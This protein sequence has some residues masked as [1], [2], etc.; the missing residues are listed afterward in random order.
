MTAAAAAPA[1]RK[2]PS[3]YRDALRSVPTPYSPYADRWILSLIP[4]LSRQGIASGI[5]LY[6]YQQTKAG[7]W[8]R[9]SYGEHARLAKCSKPGITLALRFLCDK[10]SLL[11]RRQRE[12]TKDEREIDLRLADRAWDLLA[13]MEVPADEDPVRARVVPP[14]GLQEWTVP[15]SSGG[16][17]ERVG[18]INEAAGY[19]VTV[20]P[21]E[22]ISG[23]LTFHIHSI[24]PRESHDSGISRVVKA[25]GR[26]RK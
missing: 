24:E 1:Y 25:R 2:V 15:R 6:V 20:S 9:F 12:G 17:R 3:G 21:K 7:A 22:S 10:S 11:E 13:E 4:W 14:G 26:G 19:D 16:A 23:E 5:F 18:A 8:V